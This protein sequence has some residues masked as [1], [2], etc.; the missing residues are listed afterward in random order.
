MHFRMFQKEGERRSK[1]IILNFTAGKKI[2]SFPP[3]C[4]QFTLKITTGILFILAIHE[5]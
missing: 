5:S 4:K 2:K 1:P 3:T